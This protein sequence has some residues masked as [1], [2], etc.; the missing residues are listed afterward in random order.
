MKSISSSSS[1]SKRGD[2]SYTTVPEEYDSSERE[3]CFYLYTRPLDS[4]VLSET[5]HVPLNHWAL[6]ADFVDVTVRT[7]EGNLSDGKL[8]PYYHKDYPR[9]G[10]RFYKLI[11]LRTSP[12]NLRRITINNPLNGST[13]VATSNNCQSWVR[14]AAEMISWRLADSLSK[15]RSTEDNL[16]VGIGPKIFSIMFG[17]RS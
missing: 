1:S 17:G 14:K 6:V 5:N 7:M 4:A 9:G 10:G 12:R 3:A 8:M 13:Y 16:V 2:G 11:T 15:F